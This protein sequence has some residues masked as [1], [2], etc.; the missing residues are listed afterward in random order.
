MLPKV[1]SQD[2]EKLDLEV[3]PNPVKNIANFSSDE[4][5]SFELYDMM[6]K[7]IIRRNGSTIDMSNLNPGIYF[8]VGIDK[9]NYILYKGQVLKK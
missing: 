9:N 7:L 6:D 3:Y 4:I 8:V 1:Y 5:T 2:E